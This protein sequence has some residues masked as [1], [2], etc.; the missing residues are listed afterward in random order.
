MSAAHCYSNETVSFNTCLPLLP[1]WTLAAFVAFVRGYIDGHSQIPLRKFRIPV[2]CFQRHM[3]LT[4]ALCRCNEPQY[5]EP[6]YERE[7]GT[8]QGER[9]QRIAE[10][11]GYER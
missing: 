8:P 4:D 5:N 11:G 1:L 2:C 10:N 3:E 6:G 9:N 7:M